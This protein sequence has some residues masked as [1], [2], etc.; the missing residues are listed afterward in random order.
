MKKSHKILIGVFGTIFII[1]FVLGVIGF[2]R[3]LEESKKIDD[4]TPE[5]VSQFTEEIQKFVVK[6]IGQPIE[7]FN[8]DIYSR[9]FPGLLD[10]DFDGV[11][12]L[13]GNYV[14]ES[15]KLNFERRKSG[16]ISSAEEMII[17]EGHETLF[18]NVRSRLGSDLSVDEIVR[19]IIAQG[20]GRA[21][22]TILRG[23]IC[24]VVKD[25]P[26]EECAD[27]PVFGEFI[28]KDVAGINEVARFSTQRDGSFT[29]ALPAG[30]Y[31]IESATPVGL[32][33]QAHLIEV[34]EGE[35]SEY[36]ITF[37]TGIR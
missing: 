37:D 2:M 29:V 11:E 13:E 35:I 17:K 3:G 31:S 24:P 16:S 9:A 21:S 12:T 26:D 4:S 22:G 1:S 7:G 8:A 30:E 34:R 33:I 32:G 18:N 27:Q 19:R 20:I 36:T 25:P 14:Y 15:G 5:E 23:P 10:A 28:I 6:N